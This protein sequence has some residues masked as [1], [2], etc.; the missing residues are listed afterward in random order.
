MQSKFERSSNALSRLDQ[1]G[2]RR[3]T[4][5]EFGDESPGCRRALKPCTL[6]VLLECVADSQRRTMMAYSSGRGMRAAQMRFLSQ[7]WAQAHFG[8]ASM[9]RDHIWAVAPE[10]GAKRPPPPMATRQFDMPNHGP[11]E[12]AAWPEGPHPRNAVWHC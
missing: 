10:A 4:H 11:V 2:A 3:R 6:H 9:P 7:L 12:L 1:R 8:R 5:R